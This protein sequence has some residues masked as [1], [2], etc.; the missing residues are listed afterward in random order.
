MCFRAHNLSAGLRA[1][2]G[3]YRLGGDEFALLLPETTPDE[4]TDVLRRIMA[5]FNAPAPEEC[6]DLRVSTGI[7][8]L[9]RDGFDAEALIR[10]ADAALYEAKR[11]R[12]EA[13]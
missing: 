13:P 10:R 9:S 6:V 8:T 3:A 2:D 12:S 7:A 1:S 5:V 11:Q 4:A